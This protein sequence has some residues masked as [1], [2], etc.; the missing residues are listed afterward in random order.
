[1][2]SYRRGSKGEEVRRI[3]D[4]LKAQG[5]YDGER[6]GIFGGGTESAVKRFQKAQG[7]EPDGVVGPLTWAALFDQEEIREPTILKEGLAYRCLAL[8]GSF[9]TGRPPPECFCGITGDFDGQGLSFGVLQWNLGQQSLQPLF[10]EMAQKHPSLLEDIC[11]DNYPELHAVFTSSA[12]EQLAWVR[13]VQDQRRFTLFEPWRGL[14][15]TLG[16]QEEFQQIQ[17]KHA[18]KLHRQARTLCK[19]YGLWSQR[20]VALMFD[21]KVQNGSISSLVKAQ[22]EADF[23]RL[24]QGLTREQAEQAR[25][26]IV[27]NRRAEASNPR[28]IEDV[29]RRKVTIAAGEGRVHGHQYHLADDYG[30]RLEPF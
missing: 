19:D 21:I 23:A 14:L 24:D 18:E 5:Y 12:E 30:I 20:A 26:L 13:S 15:K 29:R 17:V 2:S 22:I 3:Q 16:R 11:Q 27:A 10:R 25:L 6:D 7:L 28:W 4:R 9:E 8:T 1:M